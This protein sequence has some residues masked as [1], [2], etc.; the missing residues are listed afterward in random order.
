MRYRIFLYIILGL[1]ISAC[2]SSTDTIYQDNSHPYAD[3]NDA[4][5]TQEPRTYREPQYQ[6]NDFFFK[7]CSQIESS[8]HYSKTSYICDDR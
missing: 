5:M 6:P 7:S 4:F 8:S 2:A 3:M 1:I